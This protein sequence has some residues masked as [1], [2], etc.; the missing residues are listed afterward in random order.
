MGLHA[1][2]VAHRDRFKVAI[3]LDVA[4]GETLALLGP[5]GA[6]KSTVVDALT[7]TLELAEGAIELDGERIDLLPPERRAIGVCFQDDLLFPRLSVLENVAFPLRAQKIPRGTAH[8]RATE[9]AMRL[10]PG[11]DLFTK[12]SSLSGGE[13]QRIALARALAPEPR[14]LLLDEP[15]SNVDVSARPGLRALVREVAHTFGGATVLIAHEPL[16]A[17]TLADRVT[18]LEAGRQTQTGTP[19]QIRSAP[20]SVYAADLVGVNL[21]TGLLEPLADGAAILRT[22]DGE[23]TVSPDQTITHGA[24][25][26]ASLKPID[27]SLHAAE[28]EG[29][30]RNVF[31]GKIGE[32]A[33]DGERARVRIDTRPPLTAEVTAGSVTRMGLRDGNE[34]WASFKA[35]EVSLQIESSDSATP[36]AGTLAR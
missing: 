18:L 6:G 8:A 35:V 15:F 16:D 33:V 34:I 24:R 9:L 11:V 4:D 23:I 29:S 17:L 28:P 32:I 3:V 20:G 10:A 31:R 5:N 13:R 14:L 2:F 25:A 7:G 12:P 19:E 30:A 1:D 36:S 27:V 21:F 26:L 22:A